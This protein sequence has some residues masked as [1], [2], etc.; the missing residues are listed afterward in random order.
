MKCTIAVSNIA[1]GKSKKREKTGS[2]MVPNPKP[3]KKVNMEARSAVAT[4]I[5]YI[6]IKLQ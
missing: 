4:T 3:E 2:K 5:K 1:V 6:R